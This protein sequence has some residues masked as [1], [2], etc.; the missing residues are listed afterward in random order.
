MS[1]VF[2][3]SDDYSV[4]VNGICNEG[5]GDGRRQAAGGSAL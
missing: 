3:K 5:A 4:S 2:L 1:Q